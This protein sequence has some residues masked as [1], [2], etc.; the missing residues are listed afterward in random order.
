MG[1]S[2]YLHAFQQIVMP[3]AFSFDPDFVISKGS[4]S[5]FTCI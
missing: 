5:F 3:V 4:Q 1:D 2:D